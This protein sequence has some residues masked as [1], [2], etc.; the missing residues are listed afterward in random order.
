LEPEPPIQL[1]NVEQGLMDSIE[2]LVKCKRIT[3]PPP[4][5]EDLVNPMKEQEVGDS[6]YRFE[7][8]DAQT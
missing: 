2:E 7:G 8:G 6:P 4:T 3:G 5:L 1:V